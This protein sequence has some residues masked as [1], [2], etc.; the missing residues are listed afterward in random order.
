MIEPKACDAAN[1]FWEST[2][3]LNGEQPEA[4]PGASPE[5]IQKLLYRNEIRAN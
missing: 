4:V 3:I 1:I 2:P 5:L